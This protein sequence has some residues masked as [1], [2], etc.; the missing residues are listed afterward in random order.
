MV[1]DCP[2]ASLDHA[3]RQHFVGF[4]TLGSL[5]Y[6]PTRWFG[7]RMI[8]HSVADVS[9]LRVVARIAPRPL[10]L[11]HG[12]AD[13]TIPPHDSQL[14]YDAAGQPKQLWLVPGA[15]H[16]GSH[17]ARPAE[18]ERRVSHFFANALTTTQPRKNHG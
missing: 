6:P 15:A 4:G 18:Y 9:P 1:A 13:D 14:L 5:L 17:L 2:Y 7:E 11:I 16:V 10:L 8:G 12:M 3:V